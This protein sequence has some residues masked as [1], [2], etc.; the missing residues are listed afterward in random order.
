LDNGIG[1][2]DDVRTRLGE[3]FF[4][5]KPAP[6][7]GL[8]VN[9]VAQIVAQ[10][11][12]TWSVESQAGQGTMVTLSL[13]IARR[14]T[15]GRIRPMAATRT[16]TILIID[17]EPSVRDLLARLLKLHNHIVATAESGA[18]GI[19]AFKAGKFDLVFTDL[20]M[21]EM[22]GWDVVR[23]IK[24]INSQALVALI[25]GW[26]IDLTGEEL[27]ERGVDRVIGKPFDMPALLSLIDDAM[28]LRGKK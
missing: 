16:A 11:K 28:T 27:R 15:E 9:G 17:N 8:G 5:T 3:L 26:P 6:H 25:T 14:S 2:A 19:A 24:K 20:G 21:P 18:E 23:E 10:N 4:T 13:P 7:L 12:G 22:S 1:M